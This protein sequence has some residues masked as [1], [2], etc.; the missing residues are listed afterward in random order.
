MIP[1]AVPRL[2]PAKEVPTAQVFPRVFEIVAVKSS[3]Q[4]FRDGYF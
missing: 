1:T 3:R 2:L 4:F